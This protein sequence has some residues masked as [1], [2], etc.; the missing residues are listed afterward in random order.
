MDSESKTNRFADGVRRVCER[1]IRRHP[2]FWLG[3]LERG[4]A[5]NRDEPTTDERVWG[6]GGKQ[7]AQF[8]RY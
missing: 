6:E 5:V 8:W 7:E 2:G 4:V 3:P 1:R